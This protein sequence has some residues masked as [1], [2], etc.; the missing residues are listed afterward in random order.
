MATN[1]VGHLK[2]LLGYMN[3]KSH[4]NHS[5]NSSS[6]ND[7]LLADDTAS[8]NTR[9]HTARLNHGNGK[10]CG[11]GGSTENKDMI[12]C[13][14][15]KECGGWVHLSCAGLNSA[16]DIN[17]MEDFICKWCRA[18]G[19]ENIRE[20]MEFSL[21]REDLGHTSS[22]QPTRKATIVYCSLHS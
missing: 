8:N 16:Q 6:L 21:N 19:I 11:C 3:T 10:Y 12:E 4:G 17:G 9:S 20:G 22:T 14:C 15:G 5:L 13:I 1:I 18:S 7:S 2:G